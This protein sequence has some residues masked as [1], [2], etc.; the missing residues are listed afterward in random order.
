MI[1]IQVRTSLQ[2]LWAELSEKFSD[3]V[4]PA[5]KYGAGNENV[6]EMLTETSDLVI[7]IE[8]IEVRLANAK[9]QLSLEDKS[10]DTDKQKIAKIEERV[11][12]LRQ[13]VFENL[14]KSIEYVEECLGENDDLSD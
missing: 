4:N 3:I 11:K 2:H 8:L 5:I 6:R 13:G 9:T 12:P 14:R 1:E 7:H 10:T